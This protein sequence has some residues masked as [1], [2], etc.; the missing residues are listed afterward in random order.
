MGGDGVDVSGDR[1]LS[2]GGDE[3]MGGGA[4]RW[5]VRYRFARVCRELW[6]D[7]PDSLLFLFRLIYYRV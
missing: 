2:G 3:G 6:K 1:D 5:W 4:A 7:L